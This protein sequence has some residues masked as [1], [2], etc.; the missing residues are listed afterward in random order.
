MM[1][2]WNHIVCNLLG[3]I[4]FSLYKFTQVVTVPVAFYYWIVLLG[5]DAAICLI[6]HPVKDMNCFQF[7]ETIIN[8][9]A[10]NI[11]IQIFMWTC[12]CFSW[13]NA[14]KSAISGLNGDSMF[15]FLKYIDCIF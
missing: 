3:L 11:L 13:I 7:G 9:I 4:S 2:K 6:I 10:M 14:H 5:V 8:K 1:Y 15:S 12:F